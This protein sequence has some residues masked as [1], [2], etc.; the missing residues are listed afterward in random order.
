MSF[1]VGDEVMVLSVGLERVVAVRV[2]SGFN[3]RRVL[4]TSGTWAYPE[5]LIL[6]KGTEEASPAYLELFV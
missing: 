6:K 5:Y 3:G 2:V 4:F 1:N